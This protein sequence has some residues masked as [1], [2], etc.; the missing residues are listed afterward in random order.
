MD[1]DEYDYVQVVREIQILH[2]LS[3]IPENRFT[4]Q[5]IDI[6]RTSDNHQ[7]GVFI[8]MEYLETDLLSFMTGKSDMNFSALTRTQAELIFYNCVC[9]IKFLHSAN[10]IHRDIKPSNIVIDR[11]FNMRI[12]DF[13]LARTLPQSCV[14]QGSGNSKRV[15][16]SILNSNMT[17]FSK[18]IKFKEA[19]AQKLKKT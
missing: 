16:D 11:D 15:R 17:E 4:P 7:F 5:L 1:N 6:F 13:G 14:G 19:I 18:D 10:I 12:C 2:K 3:E 9:A 8:V